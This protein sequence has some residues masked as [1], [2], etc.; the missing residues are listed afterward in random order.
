[1]QFIEIAAVLGSVEMLSIGS[2]L[3]P[4]MINGVYHR[5]I[6]S[7]PDTYRYIADSVWYYMLVRCKG[8][9]MFSK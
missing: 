1:M 8:T 5:F 4:T 2:G 3:F 9:A 6:V 7:L